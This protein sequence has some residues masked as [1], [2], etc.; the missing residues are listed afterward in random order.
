[1]QNCTRRSIKPDLTGKSQ[2]LF[3]PILT[4]YLTSQL[5]CG[6]DSHWPRAGNNGESQSS[7]RPLLPTKWG[8][9]L[10]RAETANLWPGNNSFRGRV[11]IWKVTSALMASLRSWAKIKEENKLLFKPLELKL[12]HMQL[13]AFLTDL[14]E[15][16]PNVFPAS[17]RCS[18]WEVVATVVGVTVRNKAHE[19][20]VLLFLCLPF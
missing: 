7:E 19:I 15:R 2:K 9:L 17:A 3:F 4:W 14:A 16:G 5:A 13:T 18:D 20:R 1:M 8:C 6:V 12:C 10:P 11:S